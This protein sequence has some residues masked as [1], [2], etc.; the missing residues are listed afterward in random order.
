MSRKTSVSG[1][2]LLL[3]FVGTITFTGCTGRI[4]GNKA[5]KELVIPDFPSAKEQFQFAKMYQGSQLV[6]PELER[7]RVQMNKIGQYYQRVLV[8]FPNDPEYV[9]LTYLEL[10]DCAAQ[11][12]EFDLSISYY[13]KAQAG[14]QNEFINARSQYS[15]ARIYDSQGRY[16]DAKAI[17]KRIMDQ[18]GK[19]ENGRVRDVAA[20]SAKLYMTVHEKK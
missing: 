14:S 10:G 18:Y 4:G 16:V 17:Y 5:E 1:L 12:D 20:R 11:S 8:N 13:Q 6:Q 19:T 7:R 15:I 2:L 9:P 3:L